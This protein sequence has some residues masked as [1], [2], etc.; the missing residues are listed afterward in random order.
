MCD[1]DES[2]MMQDMHKL[3]NHYNQEQEKMKNLKV[4][5]V[6]E[7]VVMHNNYKS[8]IMHAQ[9]NPPLQLKTT[10]NNNVRKGHKQNERFMKDENLIME[11]PSNMCFILCIM[12]S[13]SFYTHHHAMLEVC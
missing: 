3:T 13:I 2:N 6:L 4:M 9:I 1:S 10:M 12:V 7:N 8:N 11:C 5:E